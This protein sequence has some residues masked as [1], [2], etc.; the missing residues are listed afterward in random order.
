MV[1]PGPKPHIGGPV[2]ST[3]QTFVTVDSVPIATVGDSVLCTGVSTTS[4]KLGSCVE[5]PVY[6]RRAL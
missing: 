4:D 5:A 3:Q 2:I 1:D 6:A